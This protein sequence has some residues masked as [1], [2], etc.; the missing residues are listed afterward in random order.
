LSAQNEIDTLISKHRACLQRI[1]DRG[2]L[3]E[4]IRRM[5]FQFKQTLAA[6]PEGHRGRF[7]IETF[8]A[9]ERRNL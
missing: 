5:A 6:L 1:L 3:K 4:N 2:E 8:A 7:Y 9:L